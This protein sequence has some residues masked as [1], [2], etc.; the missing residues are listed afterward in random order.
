MLI[1]DMESVIANKAGDVE[2]YAKRE[3]PCIFVS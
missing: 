2:T 3:K 1:V